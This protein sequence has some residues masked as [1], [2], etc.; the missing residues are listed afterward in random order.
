MVLEYCENGTLHRYLRQLAADKEELHSEWMQKIRVPVRG[1]CAYG[2]VMRVRRDKDELAGSRRTWELKERK[3]EE[4]SRRWCVQI[5][6][7]M[8]YL[9]QKRVNP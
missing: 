4:D 7:G 8:E 1:A 6:N 3:F 9:A 5:A 2:E